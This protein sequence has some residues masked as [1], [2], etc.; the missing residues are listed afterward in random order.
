MVFPC[1]GFVIKPFP[2]PFAEDNSGCKESDVKENV[3]FREDRN[4]Y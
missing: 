4:F 2:L 1:K 3:I